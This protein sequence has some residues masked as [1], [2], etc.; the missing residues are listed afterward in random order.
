MYVFT[1]THYCFD[2]NFQG[3]CRGQAGAGGKEKACQKRTEVRQVSRGTVEGEH[4]GQQRVVSGGWERTAEPE[5][6]QPQGPDEST[7]SGA[8]LQRPRLQGP[9]VFHCRLSTAGREQLAFSWSDSGLH[10]EGGWSF[11]A[12]AGEDE[13]AT[14]AT[15]AGHEVSACATGRLL[16]FRGRFLFRLRVLKILLIG[17]FQLIT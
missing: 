17:G 5:G 4:T 14:T 8:W 1:S 6:G 12:G 11:M 9:G 10:P 2:E 15:A 3:S 7:L 16:I 13:L